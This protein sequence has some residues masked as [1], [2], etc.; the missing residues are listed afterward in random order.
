MT[1]LERSDLFTNTPSEGGMF[2]AIFI[3]R[4]IEPWKF[5]GAGSGGGR[6]L[7]CLTSWTNRNL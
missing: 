2:K 1:V 6:P 4:Q 7:D 3:G 5:G